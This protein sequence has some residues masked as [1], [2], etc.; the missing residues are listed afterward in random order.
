MKSLRIGSILAA[1]VLAWT[2]AAHAAATLTAGPASISHDVA[3]GNVLACLVVNVSAKDVEVTVTAHL[4]DTEVTG[5]SLLTPGEFRVAF[6]DNSAGFPSTGHCEFEVKGGKKN[7]RAS[8]CALDE[9]GSC[10]AASPA[11]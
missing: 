10:R 3:N 4:D 11:R 8:L 9:H 5:P 6:N 1:L 2:G 7:V